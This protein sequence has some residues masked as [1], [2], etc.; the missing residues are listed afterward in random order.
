MSMA[1]RALFL[2]GERFTMEEK[3]RNYRYYEPLT[4]HDSSL[5]P[6]I[7]SIVSAEI[8][9]LEEAYA[10]YEGRTANY[11]SVRFNL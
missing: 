4:T 6:C 5:S 7:H 3:I 11:D 8:G 10:Y 9:E 1:L 2:L